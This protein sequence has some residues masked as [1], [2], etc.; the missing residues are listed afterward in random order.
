MPDDLMANPPKAPRKNRYMDVE[1]RLAAQ[2]AYYREKNLR[3][4]RAELDA[5]TV[6]CGYCYFVGATEGPIKIGY[7]ADPCR[8]LRQLRRDTPEDIRILAKV[9]GGRERE[10]Y[11]HCLF[12]D[13]H[14]G[15][16]WFERTPE[17]LAEIERLSTPT[18]L[19][20]EED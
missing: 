8:R 20:D 4:W 1:A 10:Q 19:A 5:L 12:E 13:L 16:E 3:E 2:K 17:L 9:H 7:S 15:G 18:L 6:P 11:Y 14:R